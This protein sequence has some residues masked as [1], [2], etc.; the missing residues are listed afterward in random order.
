[1]PR[2]LP[3]S[4]ARSTVV[5]ADTTTRELKGTAMRDYVTVRIRTHSGMGMEM[6][7]L[8]Q[9]EADQFMGELRTGQFKIEETAR[10]IVEKS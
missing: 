7:F 9:E 10:T 1:M 5:V 8:S 6:S 4:T 3:P 2:L